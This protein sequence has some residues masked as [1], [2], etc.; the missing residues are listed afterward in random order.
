MGEGFPASAVGAQRT[1]NLAPPVH[2][3]SLVIGYSRA[4]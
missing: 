3:G 2:I 1:M 4:F